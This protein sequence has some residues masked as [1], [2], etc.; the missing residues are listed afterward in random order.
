MV[1]IVVGTTHTLKRYRSRMSGY[2][3]VDAGADVPLNDPAYS[4][5][6]HVLRTE[7]DRG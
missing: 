3:R 5:D 6:V 2:K 7:A 4:D 1:S